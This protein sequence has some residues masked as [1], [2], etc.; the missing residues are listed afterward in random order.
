[1]RDE[2]S[3][4]FKLFEALLQPMLGWNEVREVAPVGD[5]DVGEMAELLKAKSPLIPVFA[6]CSILSVVLCAITDSGGAT[7]IAT[8]AHMKTQRIL[9]ECIVPTL[10]PRHW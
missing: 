3:C 10:P 6:F 8:D 5:N 1:M 2:V 7:T 9:E 4:L